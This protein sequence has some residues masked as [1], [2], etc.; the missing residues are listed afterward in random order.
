MVT[1]FVW[2]E[3]QVVVGAR[4]PAKTYDKHAAF[5]SSSASVDLNATLGTAHVNH[6][7]TVPVH[8]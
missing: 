3:T 8:P 5:I 6:E 4:A 7:D 2:T 1:G